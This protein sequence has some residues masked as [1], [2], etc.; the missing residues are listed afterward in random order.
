MI[1]VKMGTWKMTQMH[2]SYYS[3]CG[4]ILVGE[5]KMTSEGDEWTLV[6]SIKLPVSS[7][8]AMSDLRKY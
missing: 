2:F 4:T 3:N 5:Q 7:G 6:N 1:V 8:L